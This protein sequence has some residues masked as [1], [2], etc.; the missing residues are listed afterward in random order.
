MST[1]EDVKRVF[2]EMIHYKFGFEPV[3]DQLLAIRNLIEFTYDL[4]ANRTFIL[5]GYAGTGKT[6]LLGA[7]VKALQEIKIRSVL[8][9][10]TGRAAKVLS[11]R[12]NKPAM[13]IHK[14]IYRK[15]TVAGGGIRLAV[16]PNLS[17]YT[18]F[19]VDEASML[20]DF[21]M[22]ADGSISGR[23]L[24]EDLINYVFSNVGNKL[25]FVGDEGQLPPVGSDFSPAL[26][27]KY[28]EREYSELNLTEFR[29]TKVLRQSEDSDILLNATLLRSAAE[30]SYPS[31]Q[32]TGKP[33]LVSILGNDLQDALESSYSNF[34]SEETIVITRSNKRANQYNQQIRNRILW[35]EEDLCGG[36]VLMVVK[37]NYFWLG[38]ESAAGFIANGEI[39][40]VK[41]ITKRIEMY[42]FNFAKAQ[43]EMID[44][45]QE[46]SFEVMLLVDTLTSD[47]PSL[48]RDQLKALFFAIEAEYLFEGNKRKRYERIMKDPYF[49]ALQVKFA[50]AITCHKSQGGQW[51]SVFLDHGYLTEDLLD[52]SFFRWLYTGF[53]RASERL[54]LV[55]FDKH[56]FAEE[57]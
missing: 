43:V 56:F 16:S 45:P 33:D 19:I 38:E 47:S 2:S 50:Y 12:S 23:N 21:S 20:G 22:Q 53:T 3:E 39:L 11:Q 29:L 13:T 6:T 40:K 44:Y 52:K 15:E 37:N 36:D 57:I 41:R 8:L 51:A 30:K 31:I 5:S 54:H 26:N 10:P 27:L 55:N 17:K 35:F 25:I 48:S 42:G 9:A 14:R 32:L 49:N 24:L 34:G 28:L 46:G 7:Y 4:S 1:L 18:V